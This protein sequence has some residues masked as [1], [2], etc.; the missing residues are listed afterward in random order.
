M[1]DAPLPITLCIVNYNG[2]QYLIDALHAAMTQ[3]G[4]FA[5]ILL[6]DNASGDDSLRIVRTE[7]PQVRVLALAD[8]KGPGAARNAGFTAA[9][10]DLILFQDNDVRLQPGCASLLRS[11]LHE[12]SGALLVAPRVLYESTP[13]VIQ[14]DSAN[15]HFLGLMTLRNA[16]RLVT[17]T[18]AASSPTTSLVTACFLIDRR[19]WTGSAPFDE[20]FVFNLEDHDFGVRANL[21]GLQTWIEPRAIVRHGEGTS[22]L[23][24]R[25]GHA[26]S[27]R[28]MYYLIR[29]RWLIIG[30]SYALRTLVLLS[31]V[32]LLY[33]VFQ[34]LGLIRKG[35]LREWWQA[36]SSVL[37]NL[38]LL[39]EKR[40]AVQASRKT[41]DRLLLQPGPLPLTVAVRSGRPEKLA[42]ALMERI[43]NGYWKI[44]RDFI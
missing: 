9:S 41:P 19:R 35:W 13:E 43:A 8:N 2:A 38:P 6:V 23:S 4:G 34:L 27:S 42:I 24:Y 25:P 22:G 30:K 26:I 29:N 39:H 12:Q 20:D 7:F 21:R 28:R 1:Q 10:C 11:L 14:Y 36:L 18:E 3:A 37:R 17:Q 33:E 32:L 31:P 40:R 15:C 44:V 16:D 5:E